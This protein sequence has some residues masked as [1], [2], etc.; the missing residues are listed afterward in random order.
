MTEQQIKST[1]VPDEIITLKN[2]RPLAYGEN[3]CQNPAIIYDGGSNNP[4]AIS[5]FIE[6]SGKASYI[7]LA[8]VSQLVSILTLIAESFRRW[9]G[10]VPFI[11][12]AG[13]HGN[14]CGLGI[15]WHDP[16]MALRKALYGDPIAVMGGEVVTNFGIRSE[17]ADRLFYAYKDEIGRDRWGLD[18]IAAPFFTP[19]ADEL[20]SKRESRRLLINEALE[21]APFPEEEWTYRELYGG[22]WLKQ[23]LSPFVLTPEEVIYWTGENLSDNFFSNLIISQ[24]CGWRASSNT[25]VLAKDLSIIGVGCGQ[26][27]RRACG[28]LCL[29]R[30]NWAGHNVDGSFFASDGFLPY[31][32]SQEI[33]PK[34]AKKLMD[35]AKKLHGRLMGR[36]RREKII[37]L[38]ELSKLVSRLDR[39]ECTELFA[40][41]GC[42]GGVVPYDG[43]HKDE[44]A[45]FFEERKMSVAFVAPE[46][47]GFSKH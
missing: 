7:S 15:D 17:L 14:P 6:L 25:V 44:V 32:T 33:S 19:N 42:I 20:L 16:D 31:A 47:R 4:L 37:I 39:R 28:R 30:A 41:S 26:Q 34:E 35:A 23:R 36:N 46:N 29:D 24:A 10:I 2:G 43:N 27:D 40:D 38:D 8:D 21:Q 5:K 1:E 18:V 3:R 9:K 13:K 12:I 22:D 11:T 45:Q